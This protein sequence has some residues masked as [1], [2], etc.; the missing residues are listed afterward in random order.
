MNNHIATAP[1]MRFKKS[2]L[3]QSS[4]NGVDDDFYKDASSLENTQ[5]DAQFVDEEI[6]LSKDMDIYQDYSRFS[7]ESFT[8]LKDLASASLS[9]ILSANTALLNATT[10]VRDWGT[11][12]R[13]QTIWSSDVESRWNN[14][15]E[16]STVVS[17]PGVTMHVC[18]N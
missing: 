8:A 13:G 16:K 3:Y 17:A 18:L 1:F 7:T 4:N 15:D 12:V 14:S 10:E 9:I 6:I 5:S 11:S 2:A